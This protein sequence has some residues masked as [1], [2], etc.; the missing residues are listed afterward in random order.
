MRTGKL[1]GVEAVRGMAALLVVL[2]HAGVLL[3]GPKDYGRLPF[4]GGLAFGRAGVDI[5]FVLSGFIITYIHAGDVTGEPGTRRRRLAGFARKRLLRIYPSYWI[6]TLI[7]LAIMLISPTPDRREH[8]PAYV[9]SSVFLLPSMNEPLL[10]PGWSLRHELLFYA[11]FGLAIANRRAGIAAMALW[12]TAI[13]GNIIAIMWTGVP[14]AGGLAGSW[15][16]SPLNAE[17]LA[18]IGVT[19]LLLRTPI[20]RPLAWLAAGLLGFGL[21]ATCEVA[22]PDIPPNSPPLHL[23]YAAATF[24]ALTGL[25]AR[26][27]GT[28]LAVPAP[29]VRLG[30]ASY[31]LYLLHVIVIMIGVFVLRHLRPLMTVPLDLA[32]AALVL[33]SVAAALIFTAAIERPMLNV[34]GRQ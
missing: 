7:L 23:G 19:M 3:S 11:L 34:L 32:F 33:S 6:C 31:A 16:L 22:W 26:E 9:L 18:G 5:F 28:G 27:R 1:L 25:V 30:D 21:C 10:G 13:A 17:F 8:D 15:L 24:L 14:L 20:R 2:F 12:F 29:L 4:G